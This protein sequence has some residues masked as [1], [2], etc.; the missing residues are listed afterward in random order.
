MP[1]A[2]RYELLNQYII[3]AQER[4]KRNGFQ[5]G[6]FD[7]VH[8][9]GNWAKR[10]TG[11]DPLE[12]YRGAYK[13]QAAA[14]ALLKDR[15]GTL[16]R[17]L[18]HRFGN[19]VHPAFAQRGDIAYRKAEKACGIYFTSGARTMALFLSE[20]GFALIRARDTDWAFRVD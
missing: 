11:V 20:G 12:G 18:R 5:W 17:A 7:C 6:R 16:Y 8:F 2:D 4:Y 9:A 1:R 14:A 3:E 13:T 19:P 15:D 10:Q